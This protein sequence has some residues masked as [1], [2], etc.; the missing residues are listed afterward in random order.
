VALLPVDMWTAIALFCDT[1]TLCSLRC[2]C[3]CTR[4]G[5]AAALVL[6][7]VWLPRHTLIEHQ[8]VTRL[9]ASNAAIDATPRK[10]R[11][12]SVVEQFAPYPFKAEA[13]TA[14]SGL[15][16]VLLSANANGYICTDTSCTAAV[17]GIKL[18]FLPVQLIFRVFTQD[19]GAVR[20]FVTATQS[21][22]TTQYVVVSYLN[23]APWWDNSP[24]A[25][26]TWPVPMTYKHIQAVFTHCAGTQSIWAMYVHP[27][28]WDEAL[29]LPMAQRRGPSHDYVMSDQYT[30]SGTWGLRLARVGG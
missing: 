18:K 16:S 22:L 17:D 1:L 25:G 28:G 9:I 30:I 13:E 3:R 26:A 19:C 10:R 20:C 8:L 12:I 7:K 29:L 4:S 11:Q 14:E 6:E 27:L 2:A 21:T 5:V 23:Q 24:F 15:S